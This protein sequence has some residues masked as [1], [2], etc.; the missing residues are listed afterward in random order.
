MSIDILIVNFNSKSRV[1]TIGIAREKKLKDIIYFLSSIASI[2]SI[3]PY[4]IAYKFLF[5]KNPSGY[6]GIKLF[7]DR[8][9][10]SNKDGRSI[11]SFII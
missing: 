4:V 11:F 10:E 6:Y 7:I 1:S 8:E 9:M 5:D 2:I 3:Y